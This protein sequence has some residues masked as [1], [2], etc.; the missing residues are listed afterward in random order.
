MDKITKLEKEI[1]VSLRKLVK[2]AKNKE[3][4][5]SSWWTNSIKES[6]LKIGKKHKYRVAANRCK[7]ATEEYEF[8]WD[9]VWYVQQGEFMDRIVLAMESEMRTNA[10]ID[11]DFY[12][13]L[14]A[15][16]DLRLWIFQTNTE[17]LAKKLI[18]ECQETINNFNGL[19]KGAK[20]LLFGL[21]WNP[22]D[23]YGGPYVKP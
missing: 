4:I 11:E 8:L 13:L 2:I 7:G 12:K 5:G 17:E 9:M 18:T 19:P 10:E 15:L 21:S 14:P 23:F 20:F 22:R 6:L 1:E 3:D 16:A